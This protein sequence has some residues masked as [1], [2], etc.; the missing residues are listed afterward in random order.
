MTLLTK[1]EF[2][3]LAEMH[4]GRCVSAYLPT[5]QAG[6]EV[7]EQQDRILFKNLLANVEKDMR[8]LGF[9]SKETEEFLQPAKDLLADPVFWRNQSAGLA[10]FIG[11]DF[12][13]CFHLPEPLQPYTYVAHEYYL[14]PLLPIFMGNGNFYLLTLNFQD[15]KFYRGNRDQ[16]AEVPLPEMLPQRR[17]EVVGYDYEPKVLG[18]HSG[19]GKGNV[20]IFHG[21]AEWKEDVKEEL[22]QFFRVVDQKIAPVIQGENIPLVVACLD[23]VFPLYREANTY[24]HLFQ[25]AVTLNPE[26]LKLNHLHRK[27]WDKMAFYFDQ[28]REQKAA[29]FSQFMDTART[30][31]DI[32]EIVPAALSGLVDTL[33]LDENQEFWGVYDSLSGTVRLQEAHNRSNTSLANLAAVKVFL[34]GGQV[35][36][37]EQAFLPG[38]WSAVNA[39]Y[40]Y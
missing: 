20:A 34:S 2:A 29:L 39:L 26:S 14:K 24:A 37:Q 19:S 7:N 1:K 33:F 3:A 11:R 16:L 31:T 22:L 8:E 30:S 5:H 13:R 40:R 15:V 6:F 21:H 27:V 36:L 18:L 4:E 17:E 12:L 35:Y 28:E 9:G 23:Y 38:P 25:E 10:V 32:R